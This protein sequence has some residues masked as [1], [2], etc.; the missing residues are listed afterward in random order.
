MCYLLVKAKLLAQS[1][2]C[3]CM[4]YYTHLH[5]HQ[6]SDQCQRSVVWRVYVCASVTAVCIHILAACLCAL[7]PGGLGQSVSQNN[8]SEQTVQL[9]RC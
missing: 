8:G 5:V 9:P 1:Y 3:M 7:H 2:H 4:R 6:L